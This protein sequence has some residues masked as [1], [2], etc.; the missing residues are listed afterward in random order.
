MESAVQHSLTLVEYNQLEEENQQ[1][2]EYYQGEVF[3]MAG[4]DPKH[5]AIASNILALLHNALFDKDCTVFNSDVK[6]HIESENKS[7]YPDVSVVCGP[8]QRSEKDTRALIN[9]I[10]LVEVLSDSTAAQD[11]GS[12]FH[13]YS[14]I[15]SLQEYVLIEQDIHRAQVFYR[16]APDQRWSM[17]WY[18]GEETDVALQSIG[19][20]FSLSEFYHKTEGL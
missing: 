9:P 20:T 6:F 13:T 5:G 16:S 7:H 19:V 15:D 14:Q 18:A 3:A 8:A 17:Q 4:G 11:R 10:L 12:K 2:Y 1:R